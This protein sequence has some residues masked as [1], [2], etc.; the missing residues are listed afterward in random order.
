MQEC[1]ETYQNNDHE[2]VDLEN[3]G[4]GGLFHVS[5]CLH[6]NIVLRQVTGGICPT[7]GGE[8]FRRLSSL[9]EYLD[10]KE[11]EGKLTA[12]LS[13]VKNQFQALHAS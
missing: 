9:Q 13:L 1:S 2:I 12:E 8:R 5:A 4:C 3:G 7:P 10:K 11:S 6:C